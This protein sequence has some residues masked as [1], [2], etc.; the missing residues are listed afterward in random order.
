MFNELSSNDLLQIEGGGIQDFI[1]DIAGSI[2]AVV[3]GLVNA[4]VEM[5]ETCYDAG[6][7]LGQY[8]AGK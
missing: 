3:T 2:P 4:V 1:K 5:A 6:Y 8:I 7:K